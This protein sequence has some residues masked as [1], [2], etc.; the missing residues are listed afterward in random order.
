VKYSEMQQQ[1]DSGR[2]EKRPRNTTPPVRKSVRPREAEPDSPQLF[3][4]LEAEAWLGE[5]LKQ[6]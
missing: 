3:D 4:H 6:H 5:R 2:F 1:L